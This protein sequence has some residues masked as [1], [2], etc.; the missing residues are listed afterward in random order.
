MSTDDYNSLKYVADDDYYRYDEYYPSRHYSYNVTWRIVSGLNKYPDDVE[1]NW[2]NRGACKRE[3]IDQ[4]TWIA[5]SEIHESEYAWPQT[6]DEYENCGQIGEMPERQLYIFNFRVSP[7]LII[8]PI[9][10]FEI[11]T[12][13]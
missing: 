2:T 8:W 13:P 11:I 1:P 3:E 7:I 5:R 10:A 4:T 6:Y 12:S 9:S